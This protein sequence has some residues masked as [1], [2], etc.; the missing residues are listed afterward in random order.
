[1]IKKNPTSDLNFHLF[2]RKSENE[3]Q[4]LGIFL[5]QFIFIFLRLRLFIRRFIS[6]FI[7]WFHLRSK[8]L[9]FFRFCSF[10]SFFNKNQ[11]KKQRNLRFLCFFGWFLLKLGS[12]V[13][14]KEW[15]SP[16]F[17]SAMFTLWSRQNGSENE[18]KKN[19]IDRRSIFILFFI[20]ATNYP[21]FPFLGISF[22]FLPQLAC[23][24]KPNLPIFNNF[25][26]NGS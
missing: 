21:C 17:W 15:T 25:Q 18:K 3:G 1:M 6:L 9:F 12:F 20:F 2:R 23:I 22:S 5:Y 24:N 16:T 26:K 7:Q 8:C 13:L 19:K 11:P 14:I 4:V 10:F